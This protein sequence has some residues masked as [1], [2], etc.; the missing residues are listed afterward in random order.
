[1]YS[2]YKLSTQ[3]TNEGIALL[4]KHPLEKVDVFKLE[5]PSNLHQQFDSNVR[6]ALYATIKFPGLEKRVHFFAIHLSVTQRRN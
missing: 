3:Q 2:E 5:G 4:S 6:L 1:M